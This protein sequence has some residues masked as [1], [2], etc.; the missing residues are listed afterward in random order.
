MGA[1]RKNSE[2]QKTDRWLAEMERETGDRLMEKDSR[3]LV[4]CL[5]RDEELTC[6]WS[7]A[8]W[9]LTVIEPLLCKIQSPSEPKTLMF[10]GNTIQCCSRITAPQ[11]HMHCLWIC[12]QLYIKLC[13]LMKVKWINSVSI[14]LLLHPWPSVIRVIFLKTDLYIQ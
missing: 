14:K 8:L 5:S 2:W 6:C 9:D 11:Y 3:R 10:D 13:L 7:G 4:L 1:L 12:V